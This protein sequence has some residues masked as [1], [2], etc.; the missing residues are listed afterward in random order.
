MSY[1]TRTDDRFVLP[2][3][4]GMRD[5]PYNDRQYAKAQ[6]LLVKGHVLRLFDHSGNPTAFLTCGDTSVPPIKLPPEV[7][8]KLIEDKAV[9]HS[10]KGWNY[11]DYVLA[12]A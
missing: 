2:I 1:K 3:I 9:Q 8:Y 11:D 4:N 7:A 12:A 10:T 6:A 5:D